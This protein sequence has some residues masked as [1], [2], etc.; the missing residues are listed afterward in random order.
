M[1]NPALDTADSALIL[2]LVIVAVASTGR[3]LAA[4]T[5]ALVSRALLRLLPDPAVRIVPDHQPLRLHHELL[6]LVVGLAVGELAAHGRRHREAAWQGRHQMALLHSV[7]ELAA[8][9]KDPQLV[10]AVAAS[11]ITELLFFRDCRFTTH[12]T[13]RAM[14]G[15]SRRA[16]HRGQG[17]LVDRRPWGFPARSTSR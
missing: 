16:R 6:L 8:T 4:A 9:G 5:A 17:D 12:G 10:V 3:R 15:V 11:E 2:V 7:T 1:A 14:A 13:D